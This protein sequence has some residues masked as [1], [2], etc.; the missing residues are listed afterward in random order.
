MENKKKIIF[1]K[2]LYIFSKNFIKDNTTGKINSIYFIKKTLLRKIESKKKFFTKNFPN[3]NYKVKSKILIIGMN[4]IGLLLDRLTILS[5]KINSFEKKNQIKK[6]NKTQIEINDIILALATTSKIK[7]V[8]YQKITNQK[9]K[10]YSKNFK[11]A[12]FDLLKTNLLLWESQE[13]LYNRNI[14][15]N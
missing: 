4:S 11:E 14:L 15:K 9:V 5:L 3:Q 10:V 7:S 12:Y 1:F 8:D 6:I 13:I 2:D